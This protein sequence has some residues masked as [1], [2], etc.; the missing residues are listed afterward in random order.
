MIK[1]IIIVI[2]SFSLIFVIGFSVHKFFL[3]QN[4]SFSIVQIYIFHAISAIV[5]YSI[6]EVVASKLPNQAGYGYLMMMCL[7]IGVFVLIFQNNVFKI[8]LSQTERISL[9]VPLFLFLIA[10]A[11]AV[12]KLL[13]S[14]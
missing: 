11:L 2:L 13:N 8:E 12:G 4:L 7:K 6:I 14:K 1:R 9:V 5:V 10:E 3:T